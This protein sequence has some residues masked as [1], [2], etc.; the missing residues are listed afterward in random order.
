[1]FH[2]SNKRGASSWGGVNGESKL[3]AGGKPSERA[4]TLGKTAWDVG[5]NMV[6][7]GEKSTVGEAKKVKMLDG[8]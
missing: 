4:M 5:E 3:C 6:G 7:W 1:V 2:P 8:A